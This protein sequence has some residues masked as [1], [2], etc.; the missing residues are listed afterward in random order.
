MRNSG[1]NALRKRPT[2]ESRVSTVRGHV[3][4]QDGRVEQSPERIGETW[5]LGVLNLTSELN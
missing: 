2:L 4:L 3:S 1:V 5:S